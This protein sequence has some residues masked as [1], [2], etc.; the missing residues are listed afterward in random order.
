MTTEAALRD[1]LASKL[2]LIEP[3]LTLIE[4]E[5]P[6]PNTLG[7]KGFIDILARDRFGNRVI[8]ELKRSNQTAR[9]A[10]HEVLKYV[11]LFVGCHGLPRHRI[12]C[13]I[14]STDWHELLV[15]FAEFLKVATFQ[16]EGYVLHVDETGITGATRVEVPKLPESVAPFRN[17][18]VFGFADNT[19]RDAAVARIC[20]TLEV[21]GADSYIV[22][23]SDFAGQIL[24]VIFRYA[25]YVVPLKVR[26]DMW[27][28]IRISVD[29]EY[30]DA[31]LG[32]E[33]MAS[34]YEQTFH[35]AVADRLVDFH[36]IYEKGFAYEIGYPEKFS[37]MRY[38]GWQCA[39]I[40]RHGLLGSAAAADDQEILRMV[41]GV[42]GQS[43]FRFYRMTS[44]RFSLDWQ[45]FRGASSRCLEGNP[46][47]LNGFRW[48]CEWIEN[49]ST[50]AAVSVAIYNLLDLPLSLY[51]LVE[52][53]HPGYLPSMELA[54]ILDNEQHGRFLFGDL[55]WDGKTRPTSVA[56]VFQDLCGDL[57][58][59]FFRMQ[60]G[61][62]WE[63]DGELLRRHGLSY[64]LLRAELMEGQGT[65]TRIAVKESDG[66]LV[67]VE[68]EEDVHSFKEFLQCNERY[69][70]ELRHAIQS[71][72]AGL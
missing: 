37:R 13:L 55:V 28:K 50:E 1:E 46:A 19:D 6:L 47:W 58:E 45:D 51:K 27:Q 68:T 56:A 35:A 15:P 62:A 53:G 59:F 69:L 36:R 24:P 72:Q 31:D 71:A 48:F 65:S 14:V 2:S 25:C 40:V 34:L 18:A 10:L 57:G 64:G 63:L 17:H 16:V 4:T 5:H 29:E 43:E 61:A 23:L 7:A 67:N 20:E 49:E 30:H 70:L 38:D 66:L 11:P 60:A 54:A 33:E 9:Q 42:E 8:I 3:G 44:P 21:C 41:A 52:Y 22:V 12:R 32:P 39:K 26:D